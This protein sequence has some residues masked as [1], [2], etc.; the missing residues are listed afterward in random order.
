MAAQ[1]LDPMLHVTSFLRKATVDKRLKPV[2]IGLYMGL[3][4]QWA[5]G[6]LRN[7][8]PVDRRR[9]MKLAKISSR[10]TYHKCIRELHDWGFIHYDPSY[11]YYRGSYV[12]MLHFRQMKEVICA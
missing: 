8:F 11:D 6:R 9:A 5:Q 3:F 7:P 2:H 12:Y 4:L 1:P 10:V